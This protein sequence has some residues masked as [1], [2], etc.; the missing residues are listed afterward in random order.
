MKDEAERSM[1]HRRRQ[2]IQ[3][4]GIGLAAATLPATSTLAQAPL[5]T[6][7]RVGRIAH[8]TDVH[9]QPE[10]AGE[11]GFVAALHHVQ[12]HARPDLVLFGGD[13]VFDVAD[14]D[15][16]RRDQLGALWSRV[17]KSDLSVPHRCAIGNHD[18]PDLKSLVVA[19]A[20]P[21]LAK[22]WPCDLFGLDKR[23]Y[24]FDQFGWHIVV[25]D[26][27]SIGGRHGYEG[28]LDDAQL[29]WLAA[30]LAA[31]KDKP[32]LILSHI[33]VVTVTGFFDG[34]RRKTGDWD[35]PAS[36]VH[37][38]AVELH[39]RFVAAGNVKLCLSGHEHQFDRCLFDGITYACGGAVCGNWWKGA[40]HHTPAG[41]A[42]ID[43]YDDG[44]GQALT[45]EGQ[46]ITGAFDVAYVD[47]GWTPRE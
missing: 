37:I 47:F 39:E 36:Y 3:T 8:L 10:R 44:E 13:S 35:V 27:V 42:I 40:Y 23:Y 30:D 38:D 14:T 19:G 21:D 26:S 46:A 16:A 25:L 31:H 15:A 2:F 45:G 18:I 43:L 32:V 11:A 4:A 17:L 9:V 24:S 12:T 33:P 28:R 41:Y 5:T 22:A 34:D 1:I 6:R 7:R 29:D 20:N